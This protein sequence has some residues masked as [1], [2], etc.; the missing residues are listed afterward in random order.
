MIESFA[1][2]EP[3]AP[4]L[5]FVKIGKGGDTM[6]LHARALKASQLFM[7]SDRELV[8]LARKQNE[9]AFAEIVTRY[10]KRLLSTIYRLTGDWSTSEDLVQEVF[11][12]VFRSLGKFNPH[13]AFSTWV[14]TIARHSAYDH[15][16]RSIAPTVSLDAETDDGE[17]RRSGFELRD[18]KEGPEEIFEEN[19]MYKRIKDVLLTLPS[20]YREAMYM[21]HVEY[22]TY[23][24]IAES[25][26]IPIGTV[27]SYLFRGRQELKR[28]L[29]SL[30][31]PPVNRSVAG[32]R[33]HALAS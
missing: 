31:R 20:P 28:K 25:L 30:R 16:K 6:A 10:R 3:V 1:C 26:E 14:Y 32:T 4:L 12:K 9:L 29:A 23:T 2:R 13:F 7:L 22:R 8:Y 33:T 11:I 18:W 5:P 21:R 24:E 17:S 15:L 19:E 27:K